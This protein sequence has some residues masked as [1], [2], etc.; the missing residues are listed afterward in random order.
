MTSLL[1]ELSQLEVEPL[2]V[3]DAPEA[4]VKRNVE[5]LTDITISEV[6]RGE[7]FF[8]G[9]IINYITCGCCCLDNPTVNPGNYCLLCD[10]N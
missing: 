1:L 6:L 10:G 8:P 2:V 3:T 7:R 4:D 9:R 5:T